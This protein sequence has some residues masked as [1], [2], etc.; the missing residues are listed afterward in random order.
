LKGRNIPG[1]VVNTKHLV[2][3]KFLDDFVMKARKKEF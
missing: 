1:E 2:Q 3:T